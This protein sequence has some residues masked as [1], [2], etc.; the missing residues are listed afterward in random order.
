M[1]IPPALG[2]GYRGFESRRSDNGSGYWR[3]NMK[4]G[5][6]VKISNLSEKKKMSSYLPGGE[7]YIATIGMTGVIVYK[8]YDNTVAIVKLKNG[9][10]LPYNVSEIEE[11]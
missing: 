5:S 7:N 6:K 4:I 11:I 2:A 8:N 9:K 1:A 10:E 3:N